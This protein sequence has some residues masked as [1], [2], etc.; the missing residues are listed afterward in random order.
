MVGDGRCA[1]KTG[2]RLDLIN[3]KPLL[4]CRALAVRAEGAGLIRNPRTTDGHDSQKVHRPFPCLFTGAHY[5]GR[6]ASLACR[7]TRRQLSNGSERAQ[8]DVNPHRSQP[9]SANPE[10]QPKRSILKSLTWRALATLTTFVI[11]YAYTDE[12]ALSLG[13]GA[14]EVVTK[15]FLYYLHERLWLRVRWGRTPPGT[16]DAVSPAEVMVRRG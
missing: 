8:M 11:V 7:A 10:D 6:C 1:L 9:L 4:C 12:L 14:V 3:G 2:T 15:M 13:V 5:N 16:I